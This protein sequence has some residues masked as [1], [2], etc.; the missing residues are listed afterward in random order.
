VVIIFEHTVVPYLLIIA[1]FTP[2]VILLKDLQFVIHDG[3]SRCLQLSLNCLSA[4]LQ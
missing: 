1:L 4:S 3:V 2:S